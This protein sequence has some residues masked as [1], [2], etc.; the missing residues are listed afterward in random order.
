MVDPFQS[1]PGENLLQT[2]ELQV[3][4]CTNLPRLAPTHLITSNE[5][6]PGSL[7][8]VQPNLF[9]SQTLPVDLR[10]DLAIGGYIQ[11]S[12]KT[13]SGMFLL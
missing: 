13:V 12:E 3:M 9:V 4:N 7:E 5:E 6:T 1:T 11:G 2:D 8:L 10:D